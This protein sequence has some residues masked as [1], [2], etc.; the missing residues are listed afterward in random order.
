MFICVWCLWV[1]LGVLG[2]S[3]IFQFLRVV[4]VVRV[5]VRVR[6][7]VYT[8]MCIRVQIIDVVDG[9]YRYVR[10]VQFVFKAQFFFRIFGLDFSFF[11]LLGFGKVFNFFAFSFF[12]CEI[13]IR[14]WFLFFRLFEDLLKGIC[15]SVYILLVLI[16]RVTI[17]FLKIKRDNIV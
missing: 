9:Y 16:N 15:Y 12:F 5:Y 7:C 2:F 6:M 1:I 4:V 8:C 10:V 11:W 3:F 13:M 17:I 14:N